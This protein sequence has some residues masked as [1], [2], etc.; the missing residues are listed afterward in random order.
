MA[1]YTDSDHVTLEDLAEIDPEVPEIADA[2]GIAVE[3]ICRLAWN[4]CADDIIQ[5]FRAWGAL[6]IRWNYP[7][8]WWPTGGSILLSQ[9]VVSDHRYAR[10]RS[11]LEAWMV[12]RALEAFYRAAA[13]RRVSDRYELKRDRAT[14]AHKRYWKAVWS[15]G[16]PIVGDPLPCPGALHEIGVGTWGPSNLSAV[17]GGPSTGAYHDVAITWLD[18]NRAHNS[19]SASSK[20]LRTF[21]PDDH[22]LEVS[23]AS[24][25][26][27]RAATHWKLYVAPAGE[28]L[29]LQGA[30]IPITTQSYMLPGPP[31][32][33]TTELGVGQVPDGY[34]FAQRQL[35]RG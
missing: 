11:P 25:K 33:T 35:Q 7:S 32:T 8:L 16:L 30:P 9:I 22:V 6:D 12:Y 23:I 31:D 4:H 13:N 34:I 24:L 2:E 5:H 27:P 17:P 1:L 19:E 28:T 14:E 10:R 29:R 21:V 3:G 20:I 18:I 26:P 15:V